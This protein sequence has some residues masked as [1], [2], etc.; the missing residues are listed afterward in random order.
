M[1]RKFPGVLMA[2][3]AFATLF[4]LMSS[5]DP[6]GLALIAIALAVTLMM[7]VGMPASVRTSTKTLI[8]KNVAFVGGAGLM[9]GVIAFTPAFTNAPFM[10]GWL[11]AAILASFLVALRSEGLKRSRRHVFFNGRHQAIPIA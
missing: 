3:A 11:A 6:P 8:R 7:V 1:L 2:I 10:V 4:T 5:G 9:L